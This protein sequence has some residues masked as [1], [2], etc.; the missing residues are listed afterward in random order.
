MGFNFNSSLDCNKHLKEIA[1]SLTWTKAK[2]KLSMAKIS[3]KDKATFWNTYLY[4][5]L[6]YRLA[7]LYFLNKSSSK[8]IVDKFFKNLKQSL[9]L[10]KSTN[11]EKINLVLNFKDPTTIMHNTL[12]RLPL[13]D[14]YPVKTHRRRR[15]TLNLASI[16]SQA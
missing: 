12:N 16:R 7:A 13:L 9:G 6:S 3:L 15:I 1:N 5:K 14:Y 2:T 11:R 8:K 4:S 10:L